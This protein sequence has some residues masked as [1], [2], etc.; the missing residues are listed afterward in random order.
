[1]AIAGYP[2]ANGGSLIETELNGVV[3][4]T[5]LRLHASD[6]YIDLGSVQL[7]AATWFV[8][9]SGASSV[10]YRELGSQVNPVQALAHRFETST[11]IPTTASWAI[12][13]N[14]GVN[15]NPTG[16]GSSCFRIYFNGAWWDT[17]EGSTFSAT[18]TGHTI[19]ETIRGVGPGSISLYGTS[20][21]ALG[22]AGTDRFTLRYKPVGMVPLW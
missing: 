21:A 4:H 6:S 15:H 7:S 5:A 8:F 14:A 18:S 3:S 16:T 11:D 13:V 12:N 22:S 20:S 2:W 1:M 10:D 9:G 17:S 19:N